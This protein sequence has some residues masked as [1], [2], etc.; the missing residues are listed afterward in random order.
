MSAPRRSGQSEL[1]LRDGRVI[2]GGSVPE[3]L[4]GRGWGRMK[5]RLRF[6]LV[7]G[8]PRMRGAG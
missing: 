8:R 6:Q 5:N 2:V 3:L 7:G 1:A 4:Y